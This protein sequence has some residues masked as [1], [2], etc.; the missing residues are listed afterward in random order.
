MFVQQLS[1]SHNSLGQE[2]SVRDGRYGHQDSSTQPEGAEA[3][4]KD[5]CVLSKDSHPQPSLGQEES[6]LIGHKGMLSAHNYPGLGEGQL[7]FYFN[8][9]L[10]S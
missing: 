4:R 6:R 1:S 9:I 5:S 10:H 2:H 7:I 8:L 3:N